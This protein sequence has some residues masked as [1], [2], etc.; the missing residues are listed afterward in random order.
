VET[1]TIGERLG[2]YRI[3]ALL[4]AGGAGVVYLAEDSQLLRRVA[5]KVLGPSS[6]EEGGRHSLLQEARVVAALSHP[7]ICGIHEVGLF[8]G[9]SFIVMEHVAGVSLA[10]AIPAD[11]GLPIEVAL[12][13][14]IQIVDAVAHAHR[15]GI[16]HGDLK[17]TNVML[18]PDGRVKVLDFGLAVRY[19]LENDAT[20]DETTRLRGRLPCGTVPYMAPELLRGRPADARSDI[21]ALGVILFEMMCGRRPFG[22]ATPFETANAV[23]TGHRSHLPTRVPVTV[24]QMVAKCLS[25]RP[26]DRYSSACDLAAALDDIP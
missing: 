16:A 12:N 3:E 7:S 26:E 24:R 25:V 22:G 20:R 4:G 8:R 5:I 23:L 15:K 13:Y 1:V 11:R 9:Q 2:P 17:S 10:T 19:P 21:W 14:G 6:A 18:G